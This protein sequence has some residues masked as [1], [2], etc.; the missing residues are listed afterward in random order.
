METSSSSTGRFVASAYSRDA[1]SRPSLEAGISPK[2][3]VP[4]PPTSGLTLYSVNAFAAMPSRSSTTVALAVGRV[5]QLTVDSVQVLLA[6]RRVGPSIVSVVAN[7]LSFAAATV[8]S[9]TPDTLKRR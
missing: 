7:S 9:D 1:K 8:P 5:D 3:T 4:S 6:E 2:V